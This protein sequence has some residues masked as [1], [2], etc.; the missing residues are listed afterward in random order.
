LK[1]QIASLDEFMSVEMNTD[2][3]ASLGLPGRREAA[4]ARL[5]ANCA[6][7]RLQELEGTLG[8]DPSCIPAE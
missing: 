6:P 1:R 7:E 4:A 2:L 3:A 5:V 8:L